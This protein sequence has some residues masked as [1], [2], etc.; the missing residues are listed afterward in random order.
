MQRICT[1][2]EFDLLS[3]VSK[4]IMQEMDRITDYEMLVNI[5]AA[6]AQRMICDNALSESEKFLLLAKFNSACFVKVKWHA[7]MASGR[8][9]DSPTEAEELASD[10]TKKFLVA[11]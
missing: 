8:V 5:L 9:P 1:D 10:M 3:D 7:D 6:H 2:A 4:R 11:A